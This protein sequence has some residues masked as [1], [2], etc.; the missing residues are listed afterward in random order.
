MSRRS[1]SRTSKPGDIVIMDKGPAV[2]QMIGEAG[3]SLIFLPRYNPR[4]QPD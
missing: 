4:L 1:S 3:A 2:R